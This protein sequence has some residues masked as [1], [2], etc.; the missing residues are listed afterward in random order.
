MERISNSLSR[1]IFVLLVFGIMLMVVSGKMTITSLMPENDFEDLMEKEAKEGMHIKGEVQYA[2]DCYAYEE[3]WKENKD[4]SRTPAKTSH[5][6]YAIPGEGDNFIG[7]EVA[8]DDK[9]DM[10]T[11]ADETYEYLSG[12]E[13]PSTKIM[14]EGRMTKMDEE[15]SGLFKEYLQEIGY[16]N[17]E[18][19]GM[20]EFYYIEQPASM[21][22]ERLMFAGGILLVVIAIVIFIIR[23][24]KNKPVTEME[25][26]Q[27]EVPET[28]ELETEESENL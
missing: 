18:I 28:E 11:L 6:Y 24:K 25:T 13:E 22:T 26:V 21:Q 5:Y 9:V 8:V 12:G 14:A 15:M 20:G 4:G 2:F 23:F 7:L 17:E 27:A 1:G 19:S 16:T 3:T 10:E